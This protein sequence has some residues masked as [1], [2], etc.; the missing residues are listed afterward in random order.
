MNLKS[1]NVA[2]YRG[3][4][5]LALEFH[6]EI[7]VLLGKNGA[8]KSTILDAVASILAYVQAA[9]PDEG[10]SPIFQHLAI[11]SHARKIGVDDAHIELVLGLE[12]RRVL[13]GLSSDVILRSTYSDSVRGK[14]NDSAQDF[15]NLVQRGALN[16]EPRPLMVYY[17]QDRGFER[18]SANAA[19][20]TK[21]QALQSSL[22]GNLEAITQLQS[23]WDKRDAEEARRV[24]DFDRNYRDPQLEAIRTII[25]EIDGFKG[26]SFRS[27]DS[28]EGLYFSKE[29]DIFVHV[30]MLSS[31]ERSFIILLA[32]LARRLQM[33]HPDKPLSEAKGIVLIDE[34]EL[35]LHPQWQSKIISTIRKVFPACQFVVTTHSPQVLSSVESENVVSL[36]ADQDGKIHLS[37]P[38]RTKGQTSNYLLE[39]VFGSS[40]RFPEIDKMISGFNDAIDANDLDKATQLYKRIEEAIEGDPPELRVFKRRLSRLDGVQ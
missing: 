28:P 21:Q 12:S 2:G 3:I 11:P 17:R 14:V 18:T 33:S 19:S 23:W 38:L 9:W 30:S 36:S 7:T 27:T 40:E 20:F 22:L 39:G 4:G 34:I 29:N 32:D 10:T 16:H 8:G 25:K 31:G 35:N 13:P 6:P 15:W 5:S 1:L 26:I 37:R 24:R